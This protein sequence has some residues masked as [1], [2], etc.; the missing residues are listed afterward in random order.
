MGSHVSFTRFFGIRPTS[1]ERLVSMSV[2]R[3]FAVMAVVYTAT[4]AN[5]VQVSAAQASHGVGDSNAGTA[6][7][8]T[9]PIES[10]ID[11]IL[12]GH[13][14]DVKAA[15]LLGGADGPA[16]VARNAF[17][18]MPSA[19]AIK[20]FFLV[21]FYASHK[22]ALDAPVFEADK[23]LEDDAHPSISHFTDEQKQDIRKT[24]KGQSAR[25]IG[26]IMMGSAPASNVAY[27]AAANVITAVMGGPEKLTARIQAR[28]PAF[29]KVFVRRYMLRDRNERGDNETTAAALAVLYRNLA[30][31]SLK[32]IEP[33]THD[34]IRN[35]VIRTGS[36]SGGFEY[37]KSGALNTD[38]ITRVEAG[39]KE[40]PRG[41]EPIVFVVMLRISKPGAG[42]TREEAGK[43]LAE[44]C[45]SIRRM[46]TEPAGP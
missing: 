9:A 38:P 8:A 1:P 22:D 44:A 37:M 14:T 4:G 31:R 43:A 13:G 39:W 2:I 23:L 26:E 17:E 32:G 7:R 15:V 35:A 10:R 19:S 24:L 34:A 11:G 29:S 5:Y 18:I 25:R 33:M 27:N 12:K 36:K 42:Q 45:T 46:L 28:D 20:T 40:T 16:K 30:K 21:E 6:Q 41:K 3:H